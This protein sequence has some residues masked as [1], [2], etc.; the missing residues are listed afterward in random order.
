MQ[1]FANGFPRKRVEQ[2]EQ[3]WGF[4]WIVS[5][6]AFIF[7][8]MFSAIWRKNDHPAS[9][10][11]NNAVFEP[12]GEWKKS[13]KQGN[14]TFRLSSTPESNVVFFLLLLLPDN[15][16][17]KQSHLWFEITVGSGCGKMLHVLR[18]VSSIVDLFYSEPCLRR[19]ISKLQ[20]S[21]Q[22]QI[23]ASYYGQKEQENCDSVWPGMNT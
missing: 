5:D 18:L 12:E 14:L 6:V 17:G 23:M 8:R 13:V 7:P 10:L 19:S 4:D 15:R 21:Q 2:V 16:N 3:I 22:R 20:P 1:P 9:T 11:R